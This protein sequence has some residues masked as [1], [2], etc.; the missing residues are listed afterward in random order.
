MALVAVAVIAAPLWSALFP[1]GPGEPYPYIHLAIDLAS[2]GDTISVKSG[3]ESDP[4]VY[5]EQIDFMG[6]DILVAAREV[7]ATSPYQIDSPNPLATVIKLPDTLASSDEASVV[8][9]KHGESQDAELRG[10]TITNGRGTLTTTEMPAFDADMSTIQR[11]AYAGGGI[12]IVNSSPLI[13]RCVISGNIIERQEGGTFHSGCGAGIYCNSSNATIFYSHIT[14]NVVHVGNHQAGAGAGIYILNESKPKILNCEIENNDCIWEGS[15]GGAAGGGIAAL[16]NSSPKIFNSLISLNTATSIGGGIYL[17]AASDINPP[18]AEPVIKRSYITANRVYCSPAFFEYGGAGIFIDN[19]SA[20][21]ANNM[22]GA[23]VSAKYGGGILVKLSLT[24]VDLSIVNNT[25]Y[26]NTASDG[27]GLHLLSEN[28]SPDA[29]FF[30]FENNIVFRNDTGGVYVEDSMNFHFDYNNYFMNTFYN[31][32]GMHAGPH[33]IS[34]DPLLDMNYHLTEESPCID[35]GDNCAWMSFPAWDWDYDIDGEFRI[36]KN[37]VGYRVD[38]G[39]DETSG[40]PLRCG[41]EDADG[42]INVTDVIYL[43]S[44]LYT[45]PD[46][47]V[48]PY[49]LGDVNGDC[50]VNVTDVVV[51]FNNLYTPQYLQCPGEDMCEPEPLTLANGMA[52]VSLSEVKTISDR[53]Y[54]L[55]LTLSSSKSIAATQFE[56]SYNPEKWEIIGARSSGR[57]VNFDLVDGYDYGKYI[58][59]QLCPLNKIKKGLAAGEGPIAQIEIKWLQSGQPDFTDIKLLS[60]IVVNTHGKE[61]LVDVAHGVNISGAHKE[62]RN[63]SALE[64]LEAIPNPF[65]RSITL[66]FS[67]PCDMK[68]KIAVYNSAGQNVKTLQERVLEAGY[69]TI[70]WNG[71]DDKGEALP[72]G[73]YFLV[74]QSANQRLVKKLTLLR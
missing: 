18:I 43:F 63:P 7:G 45:N 1:V 44:N 56:L 34:A 2:D 28:G 31:Y 69:Y 13:N 62:G 52:K 33:A 72:G 47:P 25:I 35:A 48:C 30:N 71:S 26:K 41:D 21:I 54:S 73:I 55:T 42:S 49:L 51:L 50:N 9:F 29:G 61:M 57:A 59:A 58:F 68:V 66:K 46:M 11:M 4:L 3:T 19:C 39:A 10:F 15:M 65:D 14:Y 22:V 40:S 23:N 16:I 60:A 27:A 24:S 67:I 12:Y 17:D 64:L 32:S 53:T 70:N 36:R 20:K 6:K 37:T 74:L 5:E 38:I 8:Y